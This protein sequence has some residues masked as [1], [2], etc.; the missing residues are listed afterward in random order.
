MNHMPMVESMDQLDGGP[1]GDSH[2]GV[3]CGNIKSAGRMQYQFL[4]V[5]SEKDKQEP[6]LIVS[7]EK[8]SM[9]KRLGGASHFLGLFDE[10]GHTNLGH[11]DDWG[12]L[13]MFF[14]KALEL[15]EKHLGIR[16]AGGTT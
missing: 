4:F 8:N 11:S 16:P 3:L 10:H 12:N 13:E 7:S 9:Q 15:V 5:V 14:T 1:L 2:T 6:V